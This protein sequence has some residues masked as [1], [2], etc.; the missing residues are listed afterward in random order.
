[1]ERSRKQYVGVA[2]VSRT[3]IFVRPDSRKLPM[4][5]FFSRKS[6]HW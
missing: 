1:L 5:I 3:A 2:E 6:I 4:D